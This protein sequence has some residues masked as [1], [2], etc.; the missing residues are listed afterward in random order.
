MTKQS[1]ENEKTSELVETKA[2]EQADAVQASSDNDNQNTEQALESVEEGPNSHIDNKELE[3]LDPED[4]DSETTPETTV[5]SEEE[6]S[7]TDEESASETVTVN[8]KQWYIVQC[9]SNKEKRVQM[10]IQELVEVNQLE[11]RVFRVLIPE[12]PIVEIKNN[13]RVERTI[14]LYPGYIF[15]Q[16]DMDEQ[17]CYDIRRI[18]GVSKFISTLPVKDDEILKVL[19]KVGDKTKKID[20][21][22]EVGDSIKVISGPFRGYTGEISELSL[23]RG[24]IKTKIS[25]FGRE[26]PVELDFDQV[27]SVVK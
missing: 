20:V 17:L 4:E 1:I 5:N 27:E 11:D 23:D 15:V 10:R 25:I 24:K 2:E 18:P 21:D 26:T 9:F 12:E 16:M 6:P 13:Q 8:D 3:I 19:R 14:K 22:F 7:E